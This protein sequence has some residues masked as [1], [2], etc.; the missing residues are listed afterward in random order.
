VI[1]PAAWLLCAALAYA[2]G[3]RTLHR[4]GR[5]WPRRRTAAFA[6]GL[7]V[8]GVALVSPLAAH[9]E[10][11]PVHM[12]QH[13][14]L[15]MLGP[16]L[17]SLSAPVALALRT[18]PRP[19]RTELV[20]LLHSRAAAVV[21][22]TATATALFAGGLIGLYFTP[23]Y[24]ATLRHPL[25]HE[26]VHVHVLAAGCLLAWTFV[27]TDP[28]PR[29]GSMGL[30]IALLTFALGAHAAVAKLLYA[31]YGHL[32]T[33]PAAELHDGAQLMYYAGDA[34]DALLLIAFFG[35]W[36]VAGGRR[37]RATGTSVRVTAP[38]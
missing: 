7:L 34:V 37:L 18:L 26:A 30:R 29:R 4:R 33:V 35:R 9:D 31:G 25:L 21:A 16:L 15:G 1:G 19:A 8:I 3:V 38:R 32:S 2:A 20:G 13:T 14:L 24:E 36:Y 17:L 28:V 22:H 12:A 5:P 11:F 27:G 10:R 23:L 6:A